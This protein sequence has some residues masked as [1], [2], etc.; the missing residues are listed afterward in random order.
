MKVHKLL[1]ANTE[2]SDQTAR[3]HRLFWVVAGRTDHFV[4]ISKPKLIYHRVCA[5]SEDS[6]Q[7]AYIDVWS[8]F[9]LCFVDT[10]G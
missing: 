3:K 2:N 4:G 6:D 9:E 8:V 5:Q 1:Q 7:P 10:C